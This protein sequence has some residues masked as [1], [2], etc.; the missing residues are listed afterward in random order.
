VRRL[1][2]SVALL[3][4]LPAHAEKWDLLF[5]RGGLRVFVD[6]SSM[7]ITG[8]MRRAWFRVEHPGEVPGGN[9][10]PPHRSA[11]ELRRYDCD[12]KLA[13]VEE[14]KVFDGPNL[15]G[16]HLRGMA[17]K[18]I[19]FEKTVPGTVG[20]AVLRAACSAAI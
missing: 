13:G 14:R 10:W 3:A 15:T 19:E 11:L 16:Q 8:A 5:E 4:A 17:Y 12:R 7:K 1:A 6:R 18:S 20:E 2:L 9:G